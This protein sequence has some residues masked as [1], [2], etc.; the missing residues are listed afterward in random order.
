MATGTKV[1][2]ATQS[3]MAALKAVSALPLK[4]EISEIGGLH[5]CALHSGLPE[6]A[7]ISESIFSGMDVDADLA[8]LKAL[9]ECVERLA[10]I[11]GARSK[12]PACMTERSDGFAAFPL[13]TFGTETAMQ[14]ARR[15]ALN[16]AIERYAW[17][18]WW[19]DQR[20]SCKVELFEPKDGIVASIVRAVRALLPSKQVLLVRP[21]IANCDVVV[22]VLFL[23]LEDGGVVSGGACGAKSDPNVTLRALGELARHTEAVRRL[24]GGLNAAT[25]YERRLDWMAKAGHSRLL[26]S[27]LETGK[28]PLALP[29]LSIDQPI[30]HRLSD[31]VAVHRCYFENQPAFVGGDL[32]RMCL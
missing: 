28:Q 10:L 12:N 32:E 14:I 20:L 15:N 30:T 25:F 5:L 24:R 29:R 21:D 1:A 3:I 6:S 8:C 16:E 19:D 7:V 26:L 4:A 11:D 18:R 2:A 13:E 22:T 23:V 9:V 17:A 27:R 31:V